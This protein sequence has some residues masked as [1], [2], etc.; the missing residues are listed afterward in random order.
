MKNHNNTFLFRKI[1]RKCYGFKK[2]L[3]AKADGL[4]S[5][6]KVGIMQ[7]SQISGRKMGMPM[8]PCVSQSL[9]WIIIR[10][11]IIIILS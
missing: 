8:Q 3:T 6:E 7:A 5:A 1:I 11:W 9:E 2:N 4:K 10:K